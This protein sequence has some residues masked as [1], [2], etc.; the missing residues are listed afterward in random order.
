MTV[1]A[2]SG[3]ACLSIPF[4]EGCYDTTLCEQEGSIE[5]TYDIVTCDIMQQTSMTVP[6]LCLLGSI[7]AHLRVLAFPHQLHVPLKSALKRP[8]VF[9]ARD[10]GLE[11]RPLLFIDLT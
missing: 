9:C 11:Q 3:D 6:G 5:C 8:A 4:A 10:C 7:Y 2:E 1:C